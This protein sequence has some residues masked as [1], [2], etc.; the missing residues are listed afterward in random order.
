MQNEGLVQL[1]QQGDKQALS[2]LVE[3]NKGIVYKLANKFYTEKTN[4]IDIEDLQQ[5][6]FIGLITAADKYKFDIEHPCKFITYAV[7]RI[8]QRMSGFIN[9][10]NTNE[11]ISINMP[12]GD[13]DKAELVDTIKDQENSYENIEDKLYCKQLRKELEEVMNKYNTLTEREILKLHYGWDNNKC[14]ILKD[15]ALVLGINP[16]S[17]KG[18]EY[19]AMGKLRRTSWGQ[20]KAKEYYKDRFINCN[21]SIDEKIREL[22][23]KQK[24]LNSRII[25]NKIKIHCF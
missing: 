13:D 1:Y 8:Y 25:K 9:A 18:L 17:V 21:Y 20:E 5:E 6:G 2:K 24:Y 12:V 16:G 14:M 10:R 15:I 3:Q 4:S 22:D 23:F 11:E 19:K 7:Y